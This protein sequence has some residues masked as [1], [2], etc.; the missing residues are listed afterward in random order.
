[1]QTVSLR[2]NLRDMQKPIFWKNKK[3]ISKCHLLTFLPR[4]LNVKLQ[5]LLDALHSFTYSHIAAFVVA[6]F[7]ANKTF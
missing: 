6:L 7:H 5:S 3:N 1:M 4:M 2:D